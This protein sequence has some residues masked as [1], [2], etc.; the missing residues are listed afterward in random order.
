MEVGKRCTVAVSS[1][2]SMHQLPKQ[3]CVLKPLRTPLGSIYAVDMAICSHIHALCS[4]YMLHIPVC[5]LCMLI[6][7]CILLHVCMYTHIWN[8]YAHIGVV[9]CHLGLALHQVGSRMGTY[10]MGLQAPDT[11][12]FYPAGASCSLCLFSTWEY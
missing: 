12:V 6:N 8:T 7:A 9:C 4:I 2:C 5:T 1:W 10:R 3:C 11:S